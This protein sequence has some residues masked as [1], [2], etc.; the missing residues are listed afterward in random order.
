MGRRKITVNKLARDEKGYALILVLILLLL[1]SLL[2]PP[3]LGYMATGLKTGLVYEK[4]TNELYSADAG[5]EEGLWRIKSDYWGGELQHRDLDYDMKYDFN[6]T[7][8]YLTES[9]NG[10]AANVSIQNI[11]VPTSANLSSLGITPA[12]AKTMVESEKLKVT[13]TSGAIPGEPYHIKV[14]FTPASGDNLTVKSIG[15]WLPQGFTYSQGS[16]NLE[17]LSLLDDC[18]PD[19]VNITAVPGG[20]S[21][22]WSYNPP[23][24]PLFAFF[25]DVASGNST[26]TS[27]ITFHYS[28]PANNPNQL[29]VA[30][31]WVTTEMHNSYGNPK[32]P[33]NSPANVPIAWDTDTRIYKITSS[34]GNTSIEAYSSKCE[35]R[36][37]GDAIAGD[38]VAIGNSLLADDDGDHI[39]EH[40]HT[41]S[42]Y[43]L[44]TVPADG[45]VMAAYLYWSGW[46]RE[47]TKTKPFLD[48]C[49]NFNCWNKAVTSRW[50]IDS[51]GC[52]RGQYVSGG[53]RYLTMKYSQNLSPYA[54]ASTNISWYQW[55]GN[56]ALGSGEALY[57]YFSADGGNTW[58]DN[59]TAFSSGN[60][61]K[62]P[63]TKTLYSHPIPSTYLTDNFRVKFY[64]DG[65]NSGTP[66]YYCYLDDITISSNI[67][68]M[69]PDTSVMFKIRDPQVGDQQ[70][71]FDANG[72]PQVDTGGTKEIAAGRSY[73]MANTMQG[74]PE[75]F[76][77]ACVRDVTKLVKKY[78]PVEPGKLNH[79]GNTKYTVDAVSA[80]TYF[81]A[82]FAFAGWSLIIIYTS[83]GTAGHYL[84]L[85]DDNFAFNPGTGGSLDFDITNF[86]IPEPIKDKYG[87]VIETVAARLT[88]FVVEGDLWL[89]GDSV[90]ITGQ[91]SGKSKKLS[92]PASPEDNVWN[93]KS[94]PGTFNEGVDIDTFEVL[95]SDKSNGIPILTPKDTNL[96][97]DMYSSNDA[98]NLVYIILSIRSV[99]TT[100]GAINYLI[101]G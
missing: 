66:S 76:S 38:Y 55:R 16:S 63:P 68:A 85:R 20:Q 51:S 35:L 25:P 50:Y 84:Y 73:V 19:S 11:W 14:D 24:Y 53:D 8:S 13:G 3:L 59:Y 18:H 6:T 15:I 65:F 81:G 92:N 57:F 74:N 99:T 42:D 22:V 69:A 96:H 83:P 98:Y 7:W 5:I 80:D 2:I 72:D 52:F 10:G 31:A 67:S 75:G 78:S 60:L 36:K 29:P 12:Q 39:R 37:M 30:I 71:Y 26:L 94:Y 41:P 79:T 1:G 48:D 17:A 56:T 97:V 21:I 82:N 9:L 46:R 62:Y 4:K 45:D 95:W 27:T 23:D 88:C 70:V 58:S 90:E 43:T 47:S 64:L 49:S 86:V 87:S 89:S 28:P 100:S 44:T 32:F 33:Q 77:Y 91:Q 61:T 40:W 34:T 101:S 93:G 54:S